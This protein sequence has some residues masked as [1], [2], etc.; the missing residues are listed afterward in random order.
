M[1]NHMHDVV[2]NHPLVSILSAEVQVSLCGQ[3]GLIAGYTDSKMLTFFAHRFSSGPPTFSLGGKNTIYGDIA[4]ARRRTTREP[5]SKKPTDG[6]P[7][8]LSRGLPEVN[9]HYSG[10]SGL[11][12]SS[13][14]PSPQWRASL[15]LHSG[16]ESEILNRPRTEKHYFCH[17]HYGE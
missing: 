15:G 17:C 14:L 13:D 16:L 2:F 7:A 6:P 9:H 12:S 8:T 10:H 5:T 11:I 4:G 3:L 1:Q